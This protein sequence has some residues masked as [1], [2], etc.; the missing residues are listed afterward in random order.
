MQIF[1][2]M[3]LSREKK[4]EII[5]D[6]REKI[7]EQSVVYF[8]NYKGL[9]ARDVEN[10]RKDL[11]KNNANI[12]VVKKTLAKIA[13]EKEGIDFNPLELEGELAFV[14]GYG[15]II[16]PAKLISDFSKDF[17]MTI[18]GAL[19]DES[20][21][22]EGKVKKMADLPSKDQLRAQLVGT[23]AAPLSGLVGVLEGNIRGLVT[24]LQKE[25]EKNN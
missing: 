11:K 5:A 20:I 23:I 10:L 22:E 2:F 19:L 14:F 7:S 12:M 18:L 21:L 4:E 6:V 3:A 1:I 17:K 24:V 9:K 25:S 8:V 16:A 13:F 15:D